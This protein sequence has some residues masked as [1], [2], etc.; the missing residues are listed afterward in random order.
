[1]ISDASAL[2]EPSF[3]VSTLPRS[4]LLPSGKLTQLWKITIFN[5]KIHYKWQ[6][7]IA[8]LVYQRVNFFLLLALSYLQSNSVPVMFLGASVDAEVLSPRRRTRM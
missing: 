1:M 5:G 6:F 7:S 2:A 8:M 3:G 4:V